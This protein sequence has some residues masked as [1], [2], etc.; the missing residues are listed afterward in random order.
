M[1][2]EPLIK[3][4][5]N[6]RIDKIINEAMNI[7][8]NKVV[9]GIYEVGLEATFQLY[10]ATILGKLLELYTLDKDERFQLVLEK[11][12]PI[13]SQKDYVDIAIKHSKGTVEKNFLIELKFK[14]ESDSAPDLGT[15]YSYIDM[16]TL[17]V[18]KYNAHSAED[19]YYI[20]LTDLA[21][22][23]NKPTRGTRVELPMYDNAIIKSGKRYIATGKSAR[24]KT[25][26]Y[27]TG[28]SF[29]SRHKIK[30]KHFKVNTKD[31][32]FFIEKI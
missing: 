1:M 6:E 30:Y 28:F 8:I 14:K 22:Y 26:K 23:K 20:F 15:I 18:Q 5:V 9:N 29:N 25:K 24:E 32:W 12:Y 2:E 3:V 13:S 17:D 11:N 31:Y 16:Y 19:C 4:S 21:T 7:Y 10:F 27:P